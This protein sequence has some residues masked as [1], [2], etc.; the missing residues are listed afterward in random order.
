MFGPLSDSKRGG[1]CCL[2]SSLPIAM[3]NPPQHMFPRMDSGLFDLLFVHL[4]IAHPTH[5][6]MHMVYTR[7][8]VVKIRRFYIT[9]YIIFRTL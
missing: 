3:Y 5:V 9:M 2:H 8:C 4:S 1:C 6:F 7:V